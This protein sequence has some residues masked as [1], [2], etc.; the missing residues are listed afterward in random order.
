[1]H[2][3]L[4]YLLKFQRHIDR[5]VRFKSNVKIKGLFNK[6]LIDQSNIS[7]GGGQKGL[8]PFINIAEYFKKKTKINDF[9]RKE[10]S[11]KIF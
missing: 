4:L 5:N 6:E 7:E 1:M 3:K 10:E 11:L 8:K 2:L 9:F